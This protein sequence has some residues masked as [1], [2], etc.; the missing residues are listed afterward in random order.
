MSILRRTGT[1]RNNIDW[2]NA[3]SN[4]SGKYLRR[5]SNG[6]NDISFLNISS[7]GTYNILN[8]NSTGRNDISWKNTSFSFT[9]DMYPLLSGYLYLNNPDLDEIETYKVISYLSNGYNIEYDEMSIAYRDYLY[10]QLNI[11]SS[12]SVSNVD[13]LVNVIKESYSKYRLIR[14][15]N[16]YLD[17]NIANV[18]T[19]SFRTVYVESNDSPNVLANFIT[20]MDRSLSSIQFI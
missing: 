5:T 9:I 14:S 2:Y 15:N 10:I 3:S 8:R 11:D 18:R 4:S 7:N 6:R 12:V 20:R 19:S 1:G 16:N 13:I 17:I